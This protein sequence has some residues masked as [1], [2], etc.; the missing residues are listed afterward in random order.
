MLLA[1]FRWRAVHFLPKPFRKI[2]AGP[3]AHLLRDLL[4][5]QFCAAQQF[6]ALIQAEPSQIL[7]R[8]HLLDP[9]KDPAAFSPADMARRR[10][11]R[12]TDVLHIMFMDICLERTDSL[13]ITEGN[14]GLLL[15][16]LTIMDYDQVPD[17]PQQNRH[18]DLIAV[19]RNLFHLSKRLKQRTDF[20]MPGL[21]QQGKST[22]TVTI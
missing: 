12:Q 3:K 5:A 4:D 9:P 18:L 2:T 16:L 1:I 7:N 6:Q 14:R 22:K 17:L 15:D 19:F 10:D 13:A 21:F 8:R 11:I 20:L